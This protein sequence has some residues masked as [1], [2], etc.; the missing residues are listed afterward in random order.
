HKESEGGIMYNDP[1]LAIDWGIPAEEI[2]LSE[3]DKSLPFF[4]AL[5]N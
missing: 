1:D 4:K 3:K 2:I 5:S